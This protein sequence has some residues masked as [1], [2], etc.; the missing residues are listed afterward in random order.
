MSIKKLQFKCILIKNTKILSF[1]I[2]LYGLLVQKCLV[3]SNVTNLYAYI[4]IIKMDGATLFAF[5]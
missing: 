5:V 4:Y 2:L 1:E 3:L